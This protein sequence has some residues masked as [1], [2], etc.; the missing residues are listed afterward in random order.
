MLTPQ[1]LVFSEIL[2][3][4]V[5]LAPDLRDQDAWVKGGQL[6]NVLISTVRADVC[7]IICSEF[8][9]SGRHP[10]QLGEIAQ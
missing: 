9:V 7:D 5:D 2:Q 8:S 4:G 3:L 10:G 6:K 1:D